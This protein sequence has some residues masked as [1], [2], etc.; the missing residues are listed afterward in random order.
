M[1]SFTP[2]SSSNSDWEAVDS[3]RAPWRGQKVNMVALVIAAP[4]CLCIHLPANEGVDDC[5][6]CR[7]RV[8]GGRDKLRKV[9]KSQ[10][11]YFVLL[12]NWYRR[13]G[14]ACLGQVVESLAVGARL[15]QC[16]D[17]SRQ[18]EADPG[19]DARN[20]RGPQRLPMHPCCS[21]HPS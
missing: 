16:L 17:G 4:L 10:Q 7:C 14:L 6:Y 9:G 2:P 5:C 13:R 12:K 21:V 15:K 18:R 19:R 8:G 3:E 11:G 1:R 20:R